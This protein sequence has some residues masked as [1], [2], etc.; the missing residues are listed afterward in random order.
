MANKEFWKDKKVVITGC[1]GFK[2]SWLSIWL[3]MLG[4]KVYG[5]SLSMPTHPNMFELLK[6]DSRVS[7]CE[8][9]IR[10]YQKFTTF[11]NQV[12]PEIVLHLAAQP[13]VRYSYENPIET[14]HTNV[15]GLVNVFEA[16]RHNKSVKAI[17]NVTSD[18]CYENKEW[19]WGYR[20]NEPMGGYDPY[21]SSKG[22]AELVTSCYQRSYFNVDDYQKSHN[23]LLASGRAGNVIG[24]GDWAMNRLIPDMINSFIIN[25]KV[26]I[27]NPH[28][29]RPW[30]HVLEPLS[31]YLLLAENLY[32]GKTEFAS[33]WNFGPD[34]ADVKN[35]NYIADK[36]CILWG[37]NV[38]WEKDGAEHPHEASYLKLD[39]SKA[40]ALLKWKPRWNLDKTLQYTV[41]WY[42][43]YNN[44]SDLYQETVKQIT[45]YMD[46]INE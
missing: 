32:N 35:V 46:N 36:L 16:V 2:G 17:V 14:Y 43:K 27:R 41:D 42:R 26:K 10:D 19:T 31:G 8:G 24:G 23:I 13:L 3:G 28:A 44:E 4:A 1:T 33:G 5:Y 30:Q 11:L 39:C 20:E 15:V 9:D 34:N 22:C 38:S 45:T 37:N 12:N 6:I 18:K 40:H 7:Y 29:L 21:S 25:H